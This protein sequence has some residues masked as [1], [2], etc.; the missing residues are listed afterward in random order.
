MELHFLEGESLSFKEYLHVFYNPVRFRSIGRW[1]VFVTLKTSIVLMVLLVIM[2]LCAWIANTLPSNINEII[3]FFGYLFGAIYLLVLTITF[4]NSFL[5]PKIITR[6]VLSFIGK[7]IPDTTDV[8]RLETEAF[9]FIWRDNPFI[10]AYNEDPPGVADDDSDP[11]LYVKGKDKYLKI[12]NAYFYCYEDEPKDELEDELEDGSIISK[13]RISEGIYM[14]KTGFST[15]VTFKKGQRFFQKEV[16][17]ALEQ[18]LKERTHPNRYKLLSAGG[19]TR[20]L[21]HK[22]TRS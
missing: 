19:G 22:G 13:K 10:I 8:V 16:R 20:T 14:V 12:S 21:T 1:F 15:S 2:L 3:F 11:I 4:Y 6:R 17:S 9:L 7:Y 18:L 5:L